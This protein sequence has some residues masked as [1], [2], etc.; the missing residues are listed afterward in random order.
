[1]EPSDGDGVIDISA[2]LSPRLAVFPGDEPLTRDVKLDMRTGANITLSAIR[3]TVHLGTHADAPSHYGRDGRTMHEQPLSL[4]WGPCEVVEVR[5]GAPMAGGRIAAADLAVNAGWRPRHTRVLIASRTC[6]DPERWNAAFPGLDVAFIDFLASCGVRLV[7][8]DMPSVDPQD[9]KDLPA[10][11]RFLAN[12]MAIIE[13][14]VLR[15]VSAGEWEF[16]GMPLRLEG[17]DGSPVR[18]ALR[19]LRGRST[20]P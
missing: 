10:H 1:M 15:G 12:D 20:R 7:G 16:C 18:A 9:S 13:G 17:F 3:S 4:Y 14:L 2:L 8:V 19:P 6:P 11:R 5:A